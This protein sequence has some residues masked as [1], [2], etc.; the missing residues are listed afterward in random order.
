MRFLLNYSCLENLLPFIG[1]LGDD[2]STNAESAQPPTELR[3]QVR[4]DCYLVGLDMARVAGEA[5][6]GMVIFCIGVPPLVASELTLVIDP[7]CRQLANCPTQLRLAEK[8][9]L[10]V[11]SAGNHR[12]LPQKDT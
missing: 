11:R 5:D 4:R 8:P 2:R 9:D 7:Y 6:S 3:S 12:C 1:P 10:G